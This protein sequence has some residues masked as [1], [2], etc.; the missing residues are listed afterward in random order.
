MVTSTRAS[1]LC[2][3]GNLIFKF[4]EEHPSLGFKLSKGE[5]Q[6]GFA[7]HF[8]R[9]E[10][11]V[12]H[13]RYLETE[14]TSHVPWDEFGFAIPNYRKGAKRP[15]N[16]RNGSSVERASLQE[17]TFAVHDKH[18]RSRADIAEGVLAPASVSKAVDDG[19]LLSD[20]YRSVERVNYPVTAPR[21]PHED[22]DTYCDPDG[23]GHQCNQC[24]SHLI[25]PLMSPF[26]K[27]LY[28]R[29][30]REAAA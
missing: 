12:W 17:S 4:N 30:E 19:C 10:F 3:C 18:L 21:L 20:G 8:N 9:V 11:S 13:F 6:W 1:C 22:A 23:D 28:T 16:E 7:T 15:R 14:L 29:R 26:G 27:G 5:G 2:G 24:G 25:S